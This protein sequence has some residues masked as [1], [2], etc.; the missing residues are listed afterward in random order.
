M[1]QIVPNYPKG[2]ELI[3]LIIKLRYGTNL[4]GYW[5]V[6]NIAHITFELENLPDIKIYHPKLLLA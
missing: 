2:T 6:V 4:S 3:T 5:R 1:D